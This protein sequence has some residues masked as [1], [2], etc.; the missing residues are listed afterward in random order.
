MKVYLS[1]PIVIGRKLER[2]RVMGRAIRDSGNELASP[3]VLGDAEGSHQSSLNLFERDKAGSEQCDLLLADV[4]QPSIGVGMEIMAAHKA[5]KRVVVA[6]KRGSTVSRML[7]HMK[8]KVLVEFD[9]DDD[10][11]R[12]LVLL[13][14]K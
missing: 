10:L 11:Y 14:R 7:L 13:L 2:A 3:W 8:D 12:R 9:S 4:S 1:V 6:A 5:G